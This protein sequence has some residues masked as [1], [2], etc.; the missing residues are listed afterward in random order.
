MDAIESISLKSAT[1]LPLIFAAAPPVAVIVIESVPG[2]AETLIPVPP[3][4]F[5]L[6]F[7]DSGIICVPA[8]P[9]ACTLVKAFTVG[10]V[11]SIVNVLALTSGVTV[12]LLPPLRSTLASV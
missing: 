6:S 3:T 10:N 7:A 12:I 2:L 5:K 4:K 11:A 8:S 1:L 9:S